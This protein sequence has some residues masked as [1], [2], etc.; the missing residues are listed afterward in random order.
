MKLKPLLD[1]EKIFPKAM[2]Q[3]NVPQNKM[4]L[5]RFS[6]LASQHSPLTASAWT[7][8]HSLTAFGGAF[9]KKTRQ[10]KCLWEHHMHPSTANM[11]IQDRRNP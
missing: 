9:L 4:L 11:I 6:V 7:L 10:L 2:G 1:N 3:E 8:H 5:F